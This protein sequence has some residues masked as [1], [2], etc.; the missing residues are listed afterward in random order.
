M[1]SAPEPDPTT[2][3][4]RFA[5]RADAPEVVELV[6]SAYRG[7]SSRAGWT[8]EAHLLEG[9]RTDRAAVDDLIGAPDSEVLLLTIDGEVVACCHLARRTGATIYLGLFAVRPDAQGLGLGTAVVAEADRLARRWGG[10]RVRMTVISAR[11]DLL[12]WYHRLGFEPTGETE[13]F[14]Y[15]DERF[16]IPTVPDLEVLVLE[17][18]V[19][20]R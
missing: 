19:R 1:A 10:V 18:P 4:F 15:G 2:R 6:E 20:S 5:E 12:A 11:Q 16:G 9:Q 14:P 8:T 7:E 17:R 3:T 13:P